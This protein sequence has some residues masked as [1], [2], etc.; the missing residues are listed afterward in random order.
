MAAPIEIKRRIEERA[1]DIEVRIAR[2]GACNSVTPCWQVSRPSLVLCVCRVFDYEPRAGTV[3]AGHVIDK[4]EQIERLARLGLPVPRT[5]RLT[6]IY[7][8]TRRIGE[9]TWLQNRF[10]GQWARAF[11]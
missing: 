4:P 7:P 9:V 10:M 1:P 3:C 6:T 2:N 11:V 5:A 8:S